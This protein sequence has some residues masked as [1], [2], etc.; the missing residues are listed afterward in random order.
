MVLPVCVLSGQ[1]SE[2]VTQPRTFHIR[3][4]VTDPIGAVVPNVKITFQSGQLTQTLVTNDA[5][6]YEADL[7]IGNYTMAAQT[8]GFKT[9]HRPFFRVSAPSN[10]TFDVRL[11][12]GRCGDMVIVNSSGKPPTDAEIYAATES[13]RHEDLFP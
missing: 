8:K 2:P 3:G 1:S 5:G 12:L 6:R 9:Y 13:C 11:Q 7:P 4:T 10:L